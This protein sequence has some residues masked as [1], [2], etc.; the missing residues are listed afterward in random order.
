MADLVAQIVKAFNGFDAV[1]CYRK[2]EANGDSLDM[3]VNALTHTA[4]SGVYSILPFMMLSR[5]LGLTP[6]TKYS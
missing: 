1:G 4:Y 5:T 2:H 3:K 6:D